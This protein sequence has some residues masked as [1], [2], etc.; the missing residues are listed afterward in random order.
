MKVFRFLPLL[1]AV[2]GTAFAQ[3]IPI[4]FNGGDVTSYDGWG[5]FNSTIYPG[6]GAFP[7][8]TAWPNP[9]VANTPGS[10][11]A[12]L[13]KVSNA[14]GGGGPFISSTSVYFGSYT[15]SQNSFGGTL[16]I[17]DNTVVPDLKT[18]VLQ[19]QI[20]EVLGYDLY[21]GAAP[22]LS[23]NGTTPVALK[24]SALVN[25]WDT[26]T[27]FTDPTTDEE[28]PIYINTWG[29]QWDLSGIQEPITSLSIE[30]SGVKHAQVYALQLNQ[31]SGVYNTSLVPEPTTTMLAGLGA[32]LAF[33]GRR[34]C[35]R[36]ANSRS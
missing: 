5:D 30:F 23:V 18:V 33:I 10:G 31:S 2:S 25:Y 8:G 26:G 9:I 27:I 6:Y 20:G 36:G 17:T 34:R 29:F 15:N 4:N 32:A 13:N 24:Y 35:V 1:A 11:D 22:I 16:G 21:N 19:I 12:A 14:S 7:G 3:V 28:E